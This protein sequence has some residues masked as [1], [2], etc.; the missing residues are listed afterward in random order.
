M[1][2]CYENNYR[3]IFAIFVINFVTLSSSFQINFAIGLLVETYLNEILSLSLFVGHP[4]R[5]QAPLSIKYR[6]DNFYYVL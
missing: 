3:D 2:I 5:L 4:Q 1:K 6:N